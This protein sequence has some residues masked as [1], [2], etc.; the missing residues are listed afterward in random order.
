M[1]EQDLRI[2]LTEDEGKLKSCLKRLESV[3]QRQDMLEKLATAVEVLAVRQKSVDEAVREIKAD[4]RCLK[5]R[6]GKRWEALTD[7]LLYT[8]AGAFLAWLAAGGAGL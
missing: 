5:E 4:V 6:P 3:E 2:K 8:A 1:T 7:R